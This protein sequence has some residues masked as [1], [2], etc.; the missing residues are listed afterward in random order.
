MTRKFADIWSVGYMLA[1]HQ[2]G[3]GWVQVLNQK[4]RALV[5]TLAG[6]V[7]ARR[8]AR[9]TTVLLT[10]F[11]RRLYVAIIVVHTCAC[12][13]AAIVRFSC[14]WVRRVARGCAAC[15]SCVYGAGVEL[16]IYELQTSSS[17]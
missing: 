2:A 9:G 13:C 15:T 16:T 1:D 6:R 4:P 11:V 5:C 12:D 7:G 17:K 3:T 14:A 10:N 8:E